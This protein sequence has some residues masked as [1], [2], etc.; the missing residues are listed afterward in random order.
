M[1]VSFYAWVCGQRSP[2]VT[3]QYPVK[4]RTVAPQHKRVHRHSLSP[5]RALLVFYHHHSAIVACARVVEAPSHELP[6]YPPTLTPDTDLY[7]NT[8]H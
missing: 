2:L 1:A 3:D 4:A 5:L 8:N 6:I 7:N